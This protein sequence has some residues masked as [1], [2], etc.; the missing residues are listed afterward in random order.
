MILKLKNNN[1]KEIVVQTRLGNN[2]KNS[3][4]WDDIPIGLI[5]YNLRTWDEYLD[6]EHTK[7]VNKES[8]IYNCHGLTF[9]SRRTH[10]NEIDKILKEDFYKEVSSDD[11]REGDVVVY[12]SDIGVI[13]SGIVIGI[14]EGKGINVPL[15]LSKW[16]LLGEYVHLYN[17]CPFMRQ[18]E[19]IVFYRITN[20]K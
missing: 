12:V 7:Q 17:C 4:C 15:V 11:I 19:G 3:Q 14:I 18:S 13:H 9:G 6:N 8:P 10:L 16:G 2:L 5:D 1:Y 20:G